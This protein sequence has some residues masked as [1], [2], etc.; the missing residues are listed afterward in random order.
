MWKT[1]RFLPQLNFCVFHSV[2]IKC[3]TEIA[4]IS[5]NLGGIVVC[6][7]EKG[8]QKTKIDTKTAKMFHKNGRWNK[9]LTQKGL[10]GC[11]G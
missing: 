4:Q 6:V 11:N 7:G 8:K 10:L 2:K 3:F 1:A 9:I 5:E